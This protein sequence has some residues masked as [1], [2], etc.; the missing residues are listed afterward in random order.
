ML[1]ITVIWVLKIMLFLSLALIGLLMPLTAVAGLLGGPRA[2][3]AG[4]PS[5]GERL[6]MKDFLDGGV[7]LVLLICA[8]LTLGYLYSLAVLADVFFGTRL[9]GN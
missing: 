2:W 8:G 5:P 3:G 4:I 9:S 1:A 6:R 7:L